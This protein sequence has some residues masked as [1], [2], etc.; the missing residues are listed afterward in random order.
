MNRRRTRPK[1]GRDVLFYIAVTILGLLLIGLI[2]F[3]LYRL[4]ETYHHYTVEPNNILYTLNRGDYVSAW[5]DV[6]SNRA[7]GKTGEKEPGYVLPYAVADYFEAASYYA[8]YE[9]SGDTEKAA[10]YREEMER[11][12]EKMGEL[13]FMAEEIDALFRQ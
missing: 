7:A 9:E 8:V 5:Q 3:F 12:Y 10:D 2:L 6:Q 1:S 11:A 13:Q 4:H